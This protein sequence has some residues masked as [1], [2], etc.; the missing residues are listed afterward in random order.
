MCNNIREYY[1]SISKAFICN[2]CMVHVFEACVC[3]ALVCSSRS[4]KCDTSENS[5]FNTYLTQQLSLTEK[6]NISRKQ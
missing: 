3:A 1:Y 6:Q 5:D 2:I 4:L